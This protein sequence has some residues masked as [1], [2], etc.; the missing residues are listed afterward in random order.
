MDVNRRVLT[1]VLKG[2][3]LLPSYSP[4]PDWQV[5]EAGAGIEPA[6]RFNSG[7]ELCSLGNDYN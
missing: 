6:N 7:I 2:A 4:T 3:D 5:S 1:V